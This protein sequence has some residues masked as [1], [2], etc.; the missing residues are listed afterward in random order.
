M[1]SALRSHRRAISPVR[2]LATLA[3]LC[4]VGAFAGAVAGLA[5]A[6]LWILLGF[7]SQGQIPWELPLAAAAVG[8]FF[9]AILLPAAG[10]TALRTIALGRLVATTTISTALTAGV[11]ASIH[12]AGAVY[13]A[14]A[15]FLT[16]TVALWL[17]AREA[18]A[19]PGALEPGD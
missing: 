12:P 16:A 15:G 17:R 18:D 4:V 11:A 1:P 14:F 6:S 2:V 7:R 9:G 8:S 19:E 3:G 5:G 13:G 10:F